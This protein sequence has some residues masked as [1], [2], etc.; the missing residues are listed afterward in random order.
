VRTAWEDSSSHLALVAVDIY[1]DP[2]VEVKTYS[3]KLL[4]GE[5]AMRVGAALLSTTNTIAADNNIEVDLIPIDSTRQRSTE[6][7][8]LVLSS[9]IKEIDREDLYA[10]RTFWEMGPHTKLPR[11]NNIFQFVKNLG[12][13]VKRGNEAVLVL[14]QTFPQET[15]I[16]SPANSTDIKRLCRLIFQTTA[17]QVQC[18]IANV[19]GDGN[20]FVH[21]NTGEEGRLLTT[22]LERFVGLTRTAPFASDVP[23][24]NDLFRAPELSALRRDP[25]NAR[26]LSVF[27]A[28]GNDGCE[29]HPYA[30]ANSWTS[31]LLCIHTLCRHE[32]LM[33]NNSFE[34]ATSAFR[35]KFSRCLW[36]MEFDACFTA[37][38]DIVGAENVHDVVVMTKL[39]DEFETLKADEFD[40]K[41]KLYPLKIEV[42]QY[43][44]FLPYI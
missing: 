10:K 44:D 18:G 25:T 20:C 43:R 24:G 12:D 8:S 39:I 22:D 4:L 41:S 29:T 26:L 40:A 19:W 36:P 9:R 30:L 35:N 7:R 34:K 42:A 23:L 28:R 3:L 2:T 5:N 13:N 11:E 17:K 14:R 37:T 1:T 31:V 15:S 33:T 16:T 32:H 6:H 38:K 27:D 21:V